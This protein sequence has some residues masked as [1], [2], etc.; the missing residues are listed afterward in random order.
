M[1]AFPFFLFRIS[2]FQ[3]KQQKNFMK[4]NKDNGKVDFHTWLLGEN[5]KYDWIVFVS[6]DESCEC[7]VMV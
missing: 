7:S 5:K 3:T 2:I 1:E 6:N 4:K